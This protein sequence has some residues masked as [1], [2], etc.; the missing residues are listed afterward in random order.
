MRFRSLAPVL[1]LLPALA[2]GCGNDRQA[3]GSATGTPARQARTHEFP[4][5]G[6]TVELP[7]NMR[8]A[9]GG[10]PEVFDAT[11]GQ[12]FVSAFAYR[13]AEQLP[14]NRAELAAARRRLVKAVRRRE[15]SYSLESSRSTAVAGNRAVELVGTQTISRTR[16]RIRSL[17]VFRGRAEYVLE[18]VSPARGF[19]AF[20]DAVYPR[21]RTSLKLTGRVRSPS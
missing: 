4:R 12:S 18:V 10:A 16:M 21:L 3:V 2:G 8:V 19:R 6:L 14:R 9:R 15:P 20:D 1:L 5:D 11:L 7:R 13:R 17:H